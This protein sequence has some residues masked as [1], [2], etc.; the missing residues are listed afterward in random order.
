MFFY[1]FIA[2]IITF[3]TDLGPTIDQDT[4]LRMLCIAVD[5][6]LPPGEMVE[7]IAEDYAGGKRGRLKTLANRLESGST[8]GDAVELTPRLLPRRA[9]TAP[10]N[11]PRSWP[12]SSLSR[13]VSD[14]APQLMAIN[15]PSAC[16]PCM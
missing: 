3:F 2:R 5:N 12:N 14:N 9:L 11:A 15:G 8:L 6:N 1:R 13:R 16:S 7:S 10:V 4:F